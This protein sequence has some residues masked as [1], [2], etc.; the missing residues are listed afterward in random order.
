M[1]AKSTKRAHTFST[2]AL[3]CCRDLVVSLRTV[4]SP[5]AST[6]AH[7]SRENINSIRCDKVVVLLTEES[8]LFRT[9]DLN[10]K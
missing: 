1:W 9:L 2:F 3:T 10:H 5:E 8:R 6:A 4:Q 7:L